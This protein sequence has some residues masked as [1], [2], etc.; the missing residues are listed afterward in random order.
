LPSEIPNLPPVEALAY[1]RRKGLRVGFAWQDV[2]QRDHARAFTVAKAMSTDLLEDIRA[3]V[4]EAIAGGQTL[5]QFREGLTP[6]LQARGWWG[7]KDMIDPATGERRNVQLGSP[8]RLRTI[9]N[10]NMRMAY[11][12]G[13]GSG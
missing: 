12:A 7:R 3:A 13:A 2:W 8:R 9:F 4:D 1:F 5:A 6:L 11:Q 10:V